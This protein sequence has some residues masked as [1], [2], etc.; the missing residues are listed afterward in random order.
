MGL[1]CW[2]GGPDPPLDESQFPV[3]ARVE[4]GCYETKGRFAA[5]A[6]PVIILALVSTTVVRIER[7]S[8]TAC[9]NGPWSFSLSAVELER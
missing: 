1:L 6:K 8:A 2:N 7:V 5:S 9:G 4:L 3:Y